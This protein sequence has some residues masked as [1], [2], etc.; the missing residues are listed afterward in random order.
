M[1]ELSHEDAQ[2]LV[3][4]SHHSLAE[5]LALANHLRTCPACRRYSAVN[6]ALRDTLV[7]ENPKTRPSAQFTAV[8]MESVTH[9]SR[10]NQLLRPLSTATGLAVMLLLVLA[11]WFVIKS[12]PIPATYDEIEQQLFD[13][14][15]AGETGA[16]EQLLPSIYDPNIRD[17]EGNALLPLAAR[18][19]NLEIVQLLLDR[20]M[21]VNSTLKPSGIGKTAA[22]EAA[23]G[24]RS[25]IIESLVAR[26]ADLDRQESGSGWSALHY[27][28]SLDAENA[29][30]ALLESGANPNSQAENGWT[31]LFYAVRYGYLNTLYLLLENG[32][33]VNIA[34]NEG[35][36]PMMAMILRGDP[37]RSKLITAVLIQYGADPN[38]QDDKGNTALHYAAKM[39][40]SDTVSELI[41]K[42]ASP[43]LKNNDGQTPLD[44]A[45][46]QRTREELLNV[47][48]YPPQ[49]AAA[50]LDE[51]LYDAVSNIDP[52]QAEQLLKIGANANTRGRMETDTALI[53]AIKN[54]DTEM[55]ELLLDYGADVSQTDNAG[56]TALDEAAM[57]D[58]VNIIGILLQQG[59]DPNRRNNQRDGETALHAA[60]SSGNFRSAQAL[61]AGGADVNLA[62]NDGIT[63]LIK[64]VLEDKWSVLRMAK[65]F[66]DA[67][68]DPNL[69]DSF[70]RSALH[71]AQD[72][73]VIELLIENGANIDLRDSEGQTALHR[74]AGQGNLDTLVA[75][76]KLGA[77]LETEDINGN[78]PV[79]LAPTGMMEEAFQQTRPDK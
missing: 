17:Q 49:S 2:K 37:S 28:A 4:K 36:T 12:N 24:N 69:Q 1:S 35:L 53:A 11:G 77:D 59:A 64:L 66:L 73:E 32:A 54:S 5:R 56:N 76:L 65:I 72:S 29:V 47:S 22:M 16:V 13:A 14:V 45:Q 74:A 21:D 63:P 62:A 70:G 25:K 38:R 39:N 7:M 50:S 51:K 46:F 67:G 61:L 44:L 19:G 55:V 52:I 57:N 43:D 26:G 27:A 41:E 68:A 23:I 31:P 78:T 10:R 8:F 58:V 48:A 42:G 34:D 9:R 30:G 60:V 6:S 20:G 75:L 40:L 3:H 15:I 71:Y 79:D 33:D 18:A